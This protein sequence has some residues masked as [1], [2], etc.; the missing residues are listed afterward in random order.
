MI[1]IITFRS[2]SKFRTTEKANKIRAEIIDDY[3]ETPSHVTIRNWTLKVGYYEL[4]RPKEYAE[5]WVIIL[6]HSISFGKDKIFVVL[7]IREEDLKKLNRPLQY[8]DL[9]ILCEI[10]MSESNGILVSEILNNLQK[11]IGT[12]L[13]AVGD[14]GS[15]LK[16]GLCLSGIPHIYDLSHL[17]A[18]LTEKIYDNSLYNEFKKQ[19]S[20]MRTKFI[21][22]NIACIV[23]PKG[24]K[25]SEYQ[26]FDK[27]VKWAEYSLNLF[28]YKLKDKEKRAE[29]EKELGVDT[30]LR[31]EKELSWIL[32]YR[33]LI[34]E[35][36]EITIAV[37]AIEKDMKHNGLSEITLK[38]AAVSVQKLESQNGIKLGKALLLKLKE[39][40]NLLPNEDIILF[41]SDIIESIFGKFKNSVGE[42]PM[43]SV[44]VLILMI[45]AF[46]SDLTESKIKEVMENVKISDVKKWEKDKIVISLHKQRMLLLTA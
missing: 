23:P 45:A 28:D 40:F 25:K 16:K 26:S 32:D 30:I 11:E 4:M 35:L 33:E 36:T 22:T 7:G 44:T 34:T 9:E 19:M 38:N 27:T 43:A 20:L 29:L 15:D 24:R 41:S 46:T 2:G 17:I 8:S 5:D 1:L 21:Q 18:R 14:Y 3:N 37:K 42:N 13:Y 6:D 39:Q 10:P 31:I 12:I